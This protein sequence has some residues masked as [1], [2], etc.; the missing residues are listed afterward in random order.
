MSTNNDDEAH[1]QN[2]HL[3]EEN[4][5]DELVSYENTNKNI[6]DISTLDQ[7]INNV[8]NIQKIKLS[9][10][11]ISD[12]TQFLPFLNLVY[13]DLGHNSLEKIKNMSPLQNLEILILSNNNIKSIG[14]SLVALKKLQHLDLGF[15]LLEVNDGSLIKT[16][17]FNPELISLVLSGNVDYN[18][19]ICKYICLEH[20]SKLNFLDTNQLIENKKKQ[21]KLNSPYVQVQ[22]N[23]GKK[24]KIRTLKDYI[25]FKQEDLKENEGNDN[26]ENQETEKRYSPEELEKNSSSYFYIEYLNNLK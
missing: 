21:I 17:K 23:K 9:N 6:E 25:K 2:G 7:L 18:F 5:L 14:F 12:I 4:K 10:N 20:L 1:F 16:L 13:L 22:S 24:K 8:E 15:N 3:I 26:K 19:E 11:K